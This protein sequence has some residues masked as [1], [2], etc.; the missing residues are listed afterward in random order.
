VVSV[1]VYKWRGFD[2]IEIAR[3]VSIGAER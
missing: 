3:R 1:T 2:R